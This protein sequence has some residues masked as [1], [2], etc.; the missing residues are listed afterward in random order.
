[1]IAIIAMWFVGVGLAWAGLGIGYQHTGAR[2]LFG[3]A[4]ALVGLWM[5]IFGPQWMGQPPQGPLP[6]YG[7]EY[8]DT[9]Y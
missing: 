3:L 4:A 1:M 7:H 5:M 8:R 6:A 2:F 9:G